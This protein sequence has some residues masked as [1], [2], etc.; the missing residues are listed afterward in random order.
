MANE[1]LRLQYLAVLSRTVAVPWWESPLLPV[2]DYYIDPLIVDM[3]RFGFILM[4][5]KDIV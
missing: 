2:D 3:R 4:L 5:H 1:A